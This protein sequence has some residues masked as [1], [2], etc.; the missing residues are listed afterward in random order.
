MA[1]T[2]ENLYTGDG[3]TDLFSFTF[4]YISVGDVYVSIDG[5]DL[6]QTT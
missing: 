6:T 3:S 5:A 1:T 4:P 2:T